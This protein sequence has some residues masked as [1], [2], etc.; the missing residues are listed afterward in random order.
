LFRDLAAMSFILLVATPSLAITFDWQVVGWIALMFMLQTV[1]C[2]VTSRNTGIRFVANVLVLHS[3]K[4]EHKS[5]DIKTAAKA[6]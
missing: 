2:A 6:R 4:D 1:L 3:A 5:K